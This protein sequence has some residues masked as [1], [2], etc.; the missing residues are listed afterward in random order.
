MPNQESRDCIQAQASIVQVPRNT[1]Q[2]QAHWRRDE[3]GDRR[4]RSPGRKYYVSRLK[5]GNVNASS[6][7]KTLDYPHDRTLQVSTKSLSELKH[8]LRQPLNAISLCAANLRVRIEP[9]LDE[10]ESEYARRKLE[11]I[12]AEVQRLARLLDDFAPT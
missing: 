12:D 8:E 10:A 1:N 2:A 3:L 6:A 7:I 9:H 11:T 4:E 5:A